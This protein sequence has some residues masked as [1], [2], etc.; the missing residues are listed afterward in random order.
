M[1]TVPFSKYILS[2]LLYGIGQNSTSP[3][4]GIY[5]KLAN[6]T[7]LEA[8][9]AYTWIMDAILELSR[10]YRFQLL[11]RTGPL[12]TTTAGQYAYN[13]ENFY[14]PADVGFTTNLIPNLFR[15][16]LP[17]SAVPGIV[18]A[19]SNLEW[20][21]VDAQELMFNTP[22]V[23]S[24]FTRYAGQIL[25]S[26]VP[27]GAYPMYLRYQIQHPFSQ[28]PVAGDKFLLDDEWREIAEY[29]SAERG[30]VNLRMMDY[31]AQYHTTVFG[32]PEF[33]RSSGGRGMPGLIFRRITQMEGDSESMAKQIR[34]M[35]SRP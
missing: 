14:Q 27:N 8:Q 19:G 30:A 28:P 20:K 13:I 32:D 25:I 35:V 31:A 12:F 11:E 6:R 33:E 16:Y 26:P 9:G 24:Y 21:T 15:Y 17:Y 4:G 29:A 18:N 10:A 23:P 2:D 7:D 1:P 22:G 5:G 3:K 34:P